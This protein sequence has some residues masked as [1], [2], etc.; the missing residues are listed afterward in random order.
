MDPGVQETWGLDHR[1]KKTPNEVYESLV[2]LMEQFR[3]QH[4]SDPEEVVEDIFVEILSGLTGDCHPSVSWTEP[5][6]GPADEHFRK[7]RW[8]SDPPVRR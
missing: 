6:P 4:N 2:A 8:R 3:R 7:D 5:N 1:W